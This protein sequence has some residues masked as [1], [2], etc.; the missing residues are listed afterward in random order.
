MSFQKEFGGFF[1]V[2]CKSRVWFLLGQCSG[3][4]PFGKIFPNLFCIVRNEAAL[5]GDFILFLLLV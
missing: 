3:F 4:R 1:K 2:G 5:V